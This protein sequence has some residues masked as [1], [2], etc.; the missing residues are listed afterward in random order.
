MFVN[1]FKG[2][3]SSLLAYGPLPLDKANIPIKILVIS[4]ET[5][6]RKNT[7]CNAELWHV[8]RKLLLNIICEYC[9]IVN[10][11]TRA[12]NSHKEFPS[13]ERCDRHFPNRCSQKHNFYC[14]LLFALTRQELSSMRNTLLKSNFRNIIVELHSSGIVV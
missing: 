10:C 13:Q 11:Q 6:P 8:N 12:R 3:K 9:K 14:V 2:K 4:Q 5:P 1:D 7:D